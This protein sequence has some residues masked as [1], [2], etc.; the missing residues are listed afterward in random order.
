MDLPP[1][2]IHSRHQYERRKTIK[3]LLGDEPLKK[4]I[5]NKYTDFFFL[6]FRL[7]VDLSTADRT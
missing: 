5:S 7:T 6:N 4:Q 2:D 1:N 3:V